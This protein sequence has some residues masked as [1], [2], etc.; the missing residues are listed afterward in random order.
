M[1]ACPQVRDEVLAARQQLDRA[2]PC[3]DRPRLLVDRRQRLR[4]PSE[5]ARRITPRKKVEMLHR[6]GVMLDRQPMGAG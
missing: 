3:L 2:L 4:V 6:R 5:H 1:G